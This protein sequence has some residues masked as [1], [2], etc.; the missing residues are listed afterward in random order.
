MV[1]TGTLFR[2]R[3]WLESTATRVVVCGQIGI[4][5]TK[6]MRWLDDTSDGFVR[7]AAIET[8]ATHRWIK[9]TTT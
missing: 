2:K 3:R 6:R 8:N 1:G 4:E 5:K 9:P 7:I